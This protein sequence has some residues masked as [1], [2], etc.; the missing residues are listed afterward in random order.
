MQFFYG[1]ALTRI[2]SKASLY[3]K[4]CTACKLTCE[5]VAVIFCTET[6]RYVYYN[7]SN[8]HWTSSSHLYSESNAQNKF[9]FKCWSFHVLTLCTNFQV[10]AHLALQFSPMKLC[11]RAKILLT[12][13]KKIEPW[14]YPG[15]Y[16]NNDKRSLNISAALTKEI[17]S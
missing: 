9:A 6:S 1:L 5:M 13:S 3:S 7:V 12:T 2:K 15:N 16:T 4:G 8:Q 17:G 14:K 11:S 10:F